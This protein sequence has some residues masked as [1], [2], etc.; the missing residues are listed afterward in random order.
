MQ[1]IFTPG[2]VLL[3]GADDLA[4]LEA[5]RRLA[6]LLKDTP[7]FQD[8]VRL[9]EALNNDPQAAALMRQMRM[10]QTYYAL[11]EDNSLEHLQSRLEALPIYQE[12]RAAEQRAREL[13]QTVDRIV[14]QAAGI[15]F[16][17]N[18]AAPTCGCGG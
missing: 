8:F 12:Y 4:S 7:E 10:S 3:S 5:A 16:A 2:P 11:P 17:A 15:S 9:S 6:R 18:A 1:D 13:F 14:S